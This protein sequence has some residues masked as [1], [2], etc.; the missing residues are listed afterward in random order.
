[1]HR[2]WRKRIVV[3]LLLVAAVVAIFA[4]S[5][6]AQNTFIISDGDNVLVHTTYE[7]DVDAVLDEVGIELGEKDTYETT[8]E[9][10]KTEVT[11]KRVQMVTVLY[12]GETTVVGTY[13]ES[14]AS[15]L[16]GMGIQLQENDR[17]SC[18]AEAKTYNGM[19]VEIYAEEI[20][21]LE[22]DEV[23]PYDSVE[24]ESA[25]LAAGESSIVT[26]GS[27]GLIR[28]LVEVIYRNG[29][30]YS[31]SILSSTVLAE[32]QSEIRLKGSDHSMYTAGNNGESFLS[33]YQPRPAGTGSSGSS[34][35]SSGSSGG[36]SSG[37]SGSTGSGTVS[38]GGGTLTT[39]SGDVISYKKVMTCTATAYSCEGYVGHTATGTIA[40]VGAIAVDP[41]VIP[42]GTRMY[43]VSND[44][45]YIYGYAVAED[46]G[47]AIK[48]NKIDLYFNTIA[49]CYQF[50]RREC[51]VYIL[52]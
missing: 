15:L 9:D 24:Y 11:V 32:M 21:R 3:I 2:N 33:V 26:A 47:G 27:N 22:Y 43:I 42:Y 51:T 36:S 6:F 23:V 37:S 46:C 34:S 38:A 28:H 39:A 25:S 50:G 4:Q 20:R 7:T 1:M 52:D 18:D 49:E 12:H 31:R 40:R 44:G 29:E 30:E 13:G 19:T 14:V 41:R 17:M 8:Y 5:A 35:S 48:G 45:K 10:G 16:N